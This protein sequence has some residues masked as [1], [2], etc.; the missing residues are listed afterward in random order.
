MTPPYANTG[1]PKYRVVTTAER[2]ALQ[3]SQ[4]QINNLPVGF[5]LEEIQ[6]GVLLALWARDDQAVGTLR[7]LQMIPQANSVTIASLGDDLTYV[8]EYEIPAGA[9]GPTGLPLGN[10]QRNSRL[11]GASIAV[12]AVGPAAIGTH[13]IDILNGGSVVL[14]GF[15]VDQNE[16]LNT[17]LSPAFFDATIPI[18]SPQ[19]FAGDPFSILL[20]EGDIGIR[21]VLTWKVVA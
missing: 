7:Q 9:A 2:I 14:A 10:G 4:D 1:W 16:L 17:F 3:A 8:E 18:S 5:L 19:V 20:S 6:A 13:K 21:L 12:S 15:E 11:V